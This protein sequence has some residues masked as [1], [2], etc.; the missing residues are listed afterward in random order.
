MNWTLPARWIYRES[1]SVSRISVLLAAGSQRSFQGCPSHSSVSRFFGTSTPKNDGNKEGSSRG[2]IESDFVKHETSAEQVG[3]DMGRNSPTEALSDPDSPKGGD[4]T[5]P[6]WPSE[7]SEI[8]LKHQEES[9]RMLRVVRMFAG[10]TS[11]YP[12]SLW[13]YLGR[14]WWSAMFS[15]LC[16]AYNSKP[17]HKEVEDGAKAVV[18]MLFEKV[19]YWDM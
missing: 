6:D 2:R 9:G 1:S 12:F 16:N 14:W 10:T 11:G 3:A 17:L 13:R 5:Q 19:S 4:V 7:G 18:R 15:K 8:D